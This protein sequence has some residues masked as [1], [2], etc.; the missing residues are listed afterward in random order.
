MYQ[1]VD[2]DA[3]YT[4][5]NG[6]VC[7]PVATLADESGGR[8]QIDIDDHCYVLALKREDGKYKTTSHIFREA[9]EVLAG[10]PHPCSNDEVPIEL[11]TETSPRSNAAPLAHMH[12]SD[13][14]E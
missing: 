14:D 12:V 10:P 13:L 7:H 4:M 1:Q 8:C 9:F 5:Q 11:Q 3:E 6:A 2:T